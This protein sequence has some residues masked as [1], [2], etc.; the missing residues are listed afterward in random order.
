MNKANFKKIIKRGRIYIQHLIDFLDS[1][2][3]IKLIITFLIRWI[4][5]SLFF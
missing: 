2:R 3:I 5:H 4:I 1:H